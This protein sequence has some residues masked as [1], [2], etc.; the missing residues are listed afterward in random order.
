MATGRKEY[1]AEENVTFRHSYFHPWTLSRRGRTGRA[2]ER[3]FTMLS[4]LLV[5]M[6]N[7]DHNAF[8][9]LGKWSWEVFFIGVNNSNPYFL[10]L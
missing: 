5:V 4:L 9:A 8:R 10:E 6:R 1:I 3:L 2:V 7:Q